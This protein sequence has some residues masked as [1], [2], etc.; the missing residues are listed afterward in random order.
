MQLLL[1]MRRKYRDANNV[2]KNVKLRILRSRLKKI[3]LLKLMVKFILIKKV[4]HIK[5]IRE[6]M[7]LM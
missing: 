2:N 6:K 3:S 1:N 7:V 4:F 5:Y